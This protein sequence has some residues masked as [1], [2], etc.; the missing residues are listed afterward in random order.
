MCSEGKDTDP[1]AVQ[2][3]TGTK[4]NAVSKNKMSA[5]EIM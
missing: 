2:R 5:D 3:G 4:V 1:M